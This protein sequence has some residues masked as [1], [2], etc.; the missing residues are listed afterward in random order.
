VIGDLGGIEHYSWVF[1]A[2]LLASTV[3]VPLYG[4]LADL[5]GRK[6]LLLFG[7]A[8]FLVGS[9]ASGASRTM[10]Q[11]IV[12]RSLQ[13]IGAGAM[14]PVALTVV[15]DIFDLEERARMQGVFG[16]A[17]GVAG[18]IGPILGGVLVHTPIIGWRAVFYVNLPFGVAA[19]AILIGSLHERIEVRRRSLDLGGA[20]L[21]TAGILALLFGAGGGAGAL[22]A[23]AL[24]AVLLTVFVLYERRVAEPVV[25]VELFLRRVIAVSSVA[26]G[27]IGGAMIA[28]LTFVPLFVQGVL[29]G[30]ATDA[31]SAI[32]PMVIT[33]PVASALS[34]RLIPTLGFRRLVLIGLGVTAAAA[35][36]LAVV[37]TRAP[38]L[39]PLRAVTAVFG[40]GM[41]FA[42][43][44][45]LIVV[46]TSVA[47]EQRGIATASTMFFRTI[48]GTL[49][50]GVMGGVLRAALERDPTIPAGAASQLLGSDRGRSL[51][52]S[53][54]RSLAGALRVGVGTIFWLI[55]GLGVVAFVTSLFF[56]RIET[57]EPPA[58][59]GVGK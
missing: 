5:Y 33:W 20:A 55:A 32:T 43:T 28:T 16:A 7:I 14:Q 38:G 23:L 46:Q 58:T 29:G 15:G 1:T 51:D 25:P 6:P 37:A 19:A 9:A 36:A 18:L 10:T 34:G 27:V 42:N 57:A 39:W 41:G 11:L 24:A 21:L 47:W 50:V 56:P 45:L 54:A 53:V 35:I 22:P 2:Y 17:W 31:G 30:S 48:G 8:V 26:G 49:A 3:T 44:A 40:I 52:P 12:F 4:K 13:G 59:A